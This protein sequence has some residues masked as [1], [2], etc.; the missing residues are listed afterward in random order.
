MTLDGP[1]PAQRRGAPLDYD[2]YIDCQLRPIADTV[3][4]WIGLDFDT[5]VSGQQDL[6]G[7]GRGAQRNDL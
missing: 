5:I 2:H 4:G 3:L 6:F 7:T 1:Q